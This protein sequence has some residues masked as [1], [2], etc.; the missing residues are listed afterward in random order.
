VSLPARA[1]ATGRAWR[2]VVCVLD[3]SIQNQHLFSLSHTY[4]DEGTPS[5][6]RATPSRELSA[7]SHYHTSFIP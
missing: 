2:G 6:F 5:L 4:V 3:R 7:L 1:L